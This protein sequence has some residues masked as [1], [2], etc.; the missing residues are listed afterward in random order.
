MKRGVV[1]SVLAVLAG[2]LLAAG[3][4]FGGGDERVPVPRGFT[5]YRT[6]AFGFAYPASWRRAGGRDERGRPIVEFTG[7][8]LPS[9][10]TDGHIQVGRIDDFHGD[11]DA[12]LG[13]C[14]ELASTRDAPRHCGWPVRG[15]F[16][17]PSCSSWGSPRVDGFCSRWRRC[18]RRSSVVPSVPARLPGLPFAAPLASCRP[19]EAG[20]DA[21]SAMKRVNV[22][23]VLFFGVGAVVMLVLFEL[24]GLIPG[25]WLKAVVLGVG[26]P[27]LV[28][29]APLFLAE[30][31]R[32][33]GRAVSTT[34][35]VTRCVDHGPGE[36]G[37]TLT[38]EFDALDGRRVS[39]T[40]DQLP[41]RE[42]G[43]EVPVLYDP[44]DPG[45]ARYRRG[46]FAVVATAAVMLAVGVALSA[47][48]WDEYLRG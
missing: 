29:A 9:G 24:F 11:F 43:R 13:G 18:A 25:E 34:G 23:R 3:C 8:I 7:P 5:Q 32:F 48:A 36:P 42:E 19:R 16:S 31:I 39:F 22:G 30:R 46:P 28:V 45:K 27:G 15:P 10:I 33:R 6:G 17:S 40:E 12:Q 4:V 47:F 44:S 14:T 20:D 2:P 26:G 41:C 38:I 35:V 37:R 21:R 1:A